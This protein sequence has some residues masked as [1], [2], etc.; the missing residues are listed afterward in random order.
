MQDNSGSRS[1]GK[2]PSDQ[3]SEPD[4]QSNLP[5]A[6]PQ[7]AP[8]QSLPVFTPVC[9]AFEAQP[10]QPGQHQP[11]RASAMISAP[12]V[13]TLSPSKRPR[14]DSHSPAEQPEHGGPTTAVTAGYSPPHCKHPLMSHPLADMAQHAW[15]LAQQTQQSATPAIAPSQQQLVAQW[16][17]IGAQRAPVST[18]PERFLPAGSTSAAAGFWGL[19]QPTSSPEA[20]GRTSPHVLLRP[21]Q[22]TAQASQQRSMNTAATGASTSA[23]RETDNM[24]HQTA[25]NV[26]RALLNHLQ[27]VRLCLHLVWFLETCALCVYLTAAHAHS[28]VLVCQGDWTRHR[29]C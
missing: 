11:T 23:Q 25:L 4:A 5:I 10:S 15:P 27:L 21:P 6:S 28:C 26:D 20:T 3:E 9:T 12:Q 14:D 29:D 8:S 7:P 17:S 19:V 16:P 13:H 1:V 2:H 24:R 22:A 18:L